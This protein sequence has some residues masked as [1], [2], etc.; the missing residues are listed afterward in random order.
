MANNNNNKRNKLSLLEAMAASQ[1]AARTRALANSP[2]ERFEQ[3]SEP[4]H[5]VFAPSVS[6]PI[7]R[8]APEPVK[9]EPKPDPDDS[10][11]QEF[12]DDSP[13]HVAGSRVHISLGTVGCMVVAATVCLVAIGAYSMGRRNSGVVGREIP[14]LA[15]NAANPM[16]NPAGSA[17][18]PKTR[19]EERL[20]DA[21][22]T[23][24]L[25]APPTK[26]AVHQ[27]APTRA[28]APSQVV[29]PA[30]NQAVTGKPL[31]YLH[32]DTFRYG[33]GSSRTDV[34]AELQDV[35]R[36]L[37]ARGVATKYRDTG[38]EF[39][40]LGSLAVTGI[41]DA[42]A[43]QYRARVE[44]YGREYRKAGGRYEFKGCFWRSES[45]IPGKPADPPQE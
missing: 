26:P 10:V 21:D 28:V 3:D 19:I 7:E 32:I 1:K 6:A 15:V 37:A 34:L 41:K 25:Q 40:L 18:P 39:V 13:I 27:P 12:E 11:L 35:Q 29:A 38:K 2:H 23:R 16:V 42:D 17:E 22:L 30:G 8:T 9:P 44:Q 31:H 33:R 45:T 43:L 36:F 5:E 20:G 24:L 4:V 14:V